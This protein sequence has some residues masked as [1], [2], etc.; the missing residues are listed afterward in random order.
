MHIK[1]A[2]DVQEPVRFVFTHQHNMFS[3]NYNFYQLNFWLQKFTIKSE[4]A[5]WDTVAKLPDES[6]NSIYILV[7]MIALLIKCYNSPK[8]V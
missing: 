7:A 2:F 1:L 4:K 6:L 8:S 5:Y 3:F